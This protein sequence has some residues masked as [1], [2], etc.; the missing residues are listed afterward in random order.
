[1]VNTSVFIRLSIVEFKIISQSFLLLFSIGG[2]AL[3]YISNIT[4]QCGAALQL[5]LQNSCIKK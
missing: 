2:V 3:L 5:I 1:M 4:E